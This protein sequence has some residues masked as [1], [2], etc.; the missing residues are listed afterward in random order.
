MVRRFT[1]NCP[2]GVVVVVVVVQVYGLQVSHS[3]VTFL[4]QQQHNSAA[5]LS[6]L[7]HVMCQ[8]DSAVLSNLTSNNLLTLPFSPINN[9][10]FPNFSVSYVG[11]RLKILCYWFSPKSS[12][13]SA[14]V[15]IYC[16]GSQVR[17]TPHWKTFW[18]VVWFKKMCSKIW[19]LTLLEILK[20]LC[21]LLLKW[22]IPTPSTF[23]FLLWTHVSHIK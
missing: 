16:S 13:F 2:W 20:V 12:Q 22:R 23:L 10:I 5:Q 15:K 19:F 21:I 6:R 3:T 14:M 1:G 4:C 11:F 8:I 7:Y 9:I 17:S 18:S